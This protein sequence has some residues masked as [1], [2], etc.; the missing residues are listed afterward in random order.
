L[1]RTEK[2]QAKENCK[3][4]IRSIL[5]GI[6]STLERLIYV[7]SRKDLTTGR[8]EDASLARECERDHFDQILRGKHLAVFRDWLCCDLHAQTLELESHFANQGVSSR[9]L[10]QD[11]IEQKSFEQYIPA[12]AAKPERLLFK[13]DIE[14]VLQLLLADRS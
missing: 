11:W 4:L 10:L 13:A 14:L 3:R 7:S 6:P 2:D 5:C 12:E 9:A 1:T 8:Y